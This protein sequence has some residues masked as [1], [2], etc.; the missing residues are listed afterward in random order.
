M[1]GMFVFKGTEIF[2]EGVMLYCENLGD[3]NICERMSWSVFLP[4]ADRVLPALLDELTCTEPIIFVCRVADLHQQFHISSSWPMPFHALPDPFLVYL[5]DCW[6]NHHF[7][8][9]R[10]MVKL[11]LR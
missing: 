9:F 2:P 10:V 7:I 1:R 4:D 11:W 5:G 8:C 6:A 3:G